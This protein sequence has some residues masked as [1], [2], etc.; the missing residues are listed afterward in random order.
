M[1]NYWI[2]EVDLE[3]I[4]YLDSTQHG[5]FGPDGTIS[6]IY[7][8]MIPKGQNIF[9]LGHLWECHSWQRGWH[10]ICLSLARQR[11]LAPCRSFEKVCS[12]D[13]RQLNSER[14][15][16]QTLLYGTVVL[17]NKYQLWFRIDAYPLLD[18][19]NYPYQLYIRSPTNLSVTLQH[20]LFVISVCEYLHS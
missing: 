10:V 19:S 17:V 8:I 4:A 15:L 7:C 5:Y 14:Y 13:Y 11:W 3:S 1:G 9:H 18:P 20:I 6:D 12:C 2:R 16:Y